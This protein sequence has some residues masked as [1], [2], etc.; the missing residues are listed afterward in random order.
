MA[1]AQL[2]AQETQRHP[3]ADTIHPGRHL[4]P[5]FDGAAEIEVASILEGKVAAS[6]EPN[7]EQVREI[8][9]GAESRRSEAARRALE[10]STV[11][12]FGRLEAEYERRFEAL[13][14][15]LQQRFD[16]ACEMLEAETRERRRAAAEQHD[17]LM[18]RLAAA[19]E[20]LGQAKTSRE[21]LADLL[22]HVAS[23]LRAA[24][25]PT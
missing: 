25:Q 17:E 8:L 24:A 20:F 3:M 4:S 7:L 11:E 12:K 1:S 2:S 13:L 16:K 21:E 22:T 18:K 10:A 9:F 19:S 14:R 5:T 23:H 15:E 6:Q